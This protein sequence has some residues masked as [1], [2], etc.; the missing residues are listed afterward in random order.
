MMRRWLWLFLLLL[1]FVG[2]A[3]SQVQPIR[4][5]SAVSAGARL[6]RLHSLLVSHRGILVLEKYYNGIRPTKLANIKSASKTVLSALVGIAIERGHIPSVKQPIQ[7]YFTYVL[8][9]DK[10]V[11][12][13]SITVEDLLTMRSGLQTTSNRN[14]GAWVLSSNWVRHALTRPLVNSPGTRMEYSTGNTHLLSAILT[15]ATRSNTWKFAQEVLAKPMGFSLPA[16]PTDPQGIYF[17]GNDMLMTPRQ[18]LTFGEMYLNRGRINN[19][20]IVPSQWV[21]ASLVAR[22]PSPREYGRSYGYGWWIRDLGGHET[23]Y[24]WGYGGQFIFLVPDLQLVVVTTSSSTPG[25]ERREHL[26]AI[27]QLVEEQIIKSLSSVA[28]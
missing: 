20:Q 13:R 24:A 7:A 18:M 22:T 27:Y 2:P 25:S 19:Q 28:N 16:W 21:E 10:D 6:P 5:D 17:G 4:F 11:R 23:Y 15:K 14:Y 9:A 26:Q 12:K 1:L 8:A 3:Y